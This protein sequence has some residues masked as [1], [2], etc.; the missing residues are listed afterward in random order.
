GDVGAQP[1][2]ERRGGGGPLRRTVREREQGIEEPA[3]RRVGDDLANRG[4][5]HRRSGRL[6]AAGGAARLDRAGKRR[7]GERRGARGGRE[8]EGGG[9]GR[10]RKRGRSEGREPPGGNGAR[11]SAPPQVGGRGQQ[12]Q[13]RADGRPG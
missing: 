13:H 1:R 7:G 11:S 3:A 2:G 12:E 6:G 8:V 10:G 5:R 4:K 9:H